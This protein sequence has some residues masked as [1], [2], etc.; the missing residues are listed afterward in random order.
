MAVLETIRVKFG[1]I[2]TALIAVALL[3]FII[4]PTTLQSVL[5]SSQEENTVGEINGESVTYSEFANEVDRVSVASEMLSGVSSSNEQQ[6]KMIKDNAWQSLINR[7]LFLKN[8]EK[9]G[10]TVTEGELESI[11]SGEIESPVITQNPIF[12]D[13]NGVFNPFNSYGILV[14]D[15]TQVKL[16]SVNFIGPMQKK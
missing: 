11:M 12:M 16:D 14:Q 1:I 15:S 4:D 8:A 13:E 9:A 10:I 6:Q 7:R 3:S 2:I 5:G